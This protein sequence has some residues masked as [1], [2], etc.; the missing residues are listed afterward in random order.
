MQSLDVIS[1]N[2]WQLLVSLLNLVIIFVIV[3]RFLYKPVKKMLTNRQNAIEEDY[4]RAE[5]AKNQ[6]LTE[7]QQYEEKLSGA[8]KE[9]DGVIRSAVK[10]AKARENEIIE[11]AKAEAQGIVSRAKEDAL[12]EKKKAENE[13]KK[14]IIEVGALLSEKMLKREINKEDH[15]EMIDS[16]IEEIGEENDADS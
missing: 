16:F 5:E 1:V 9:A 7:K 8:K 2:L 12:L 6:A 4:N 3:K 10:I 15:K 14:E 13:V 11:N